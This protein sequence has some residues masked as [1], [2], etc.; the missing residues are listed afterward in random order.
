M[1]IGPK[2]SVIVPVY[3]VESYLR[4]CLD[5]IVNQ[6]YRNLE[7]ILVD[8]GSPDNCGAICDEY[9]SKDDRII[10]IHQKNAGQSAA[11]NAAL[12]RATGTHIACVDSDDWLELDYF[13]FLLEQMQLEQAEI[14]VCGMSLE[15]DGRRGKSG[16][17]CRMVLNKIEAMEL[18][19][20]DV[21]LQS[22]VG[23]K[24]W[25]Q[26]LFRDIRFPVGRISEDYAVMHLLFERA[27]T[28]VCLPEEKY[29]YRQWH[30][31]TMANWSVAY[32]MDRLQ[33]I[34]ERLEYMNVHWPRLAGALQHTLVRNTMPIWSNYLFYSRA[35]RKSAMPYLQLSTDFCRCHRMEIQEQYQFG[36]SGRM[37]LWLMCHMSWW[38]F[39]L[40]AILN[41][42]Y[43]RRYGHGM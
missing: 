14:V 38:S 7:I 21:V 8:D 29:H 10:V 27:K 16:V 4:Q 22:G 12:D 24:M 17:E 33:A 23:A 1:E 39:A 18:L 35:E 28:V 36:L 34:L 42:L 31:S 9:A 5:S 15:Y 25:K 13:K 43:C 26:E 3:K 40:A 41:T 20:E 30:G 32:R 19:V 2:I 37:I 6:T 11:R